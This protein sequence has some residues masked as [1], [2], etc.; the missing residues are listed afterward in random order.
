M[1]L[2]EW[3]SFTLFLY[4]YETSSFTLG[5]N[6]DW[7]RLITGY[8]REYLYQREKKQQEAEKIT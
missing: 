3:A 5:E 7:G 2:N 6:I 4:E 8:K 1:I